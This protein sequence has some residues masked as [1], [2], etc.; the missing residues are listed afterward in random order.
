MTPTP[1]PIRVNQLL[2]LVV[3][4]L[5]LVSGCS[6]VE[7]VR[8]AVNSVTPIRSAPEPVR[9][10]L[11][12]ICDANEATRT[13]ECKTTRTEDGTVIADPRNNPQPPAAAAT[14]DGG[15]VPA[16]P[17]EAEAD[18]AVR[19]AAVARPPASPA[20]RGAVMQTPSGMILA[21][22]PDAFA[23]QLI[24]LNDESAIIAYALEQG[25]EQPIYAQT[26]T[27]DDALFVLILGVYPDRGTADTA[28]AEF[29]EGR[30]LAVSPWV[31]PLGPLQQAVRALNAN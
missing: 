21:S 22:P 29:V 30:R 4:G 24:A 8:T 1:Q 3:L 16:G 18:P 2:V 23:V 14:R 11:Y 10:P 31:R 6:T 27:G 20:A 7:R 26:R 17:D 5:A 15:D 25:I 28:R 19:P 13:W 9:S 12:Y